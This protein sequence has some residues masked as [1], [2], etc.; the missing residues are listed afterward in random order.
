MRNYDA[1]VMI[2]NKNAPI[3]SGAK[4]IY[5]KEYIK[6]FCF[7]IKANTTPQM[8]IEKTPQYRHKI[9]GCMFF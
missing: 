9:L 1:L 7:L 8:Q 6:T 3:L 2:F 5:Q 4:R